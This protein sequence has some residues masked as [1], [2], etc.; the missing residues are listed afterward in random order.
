MALCFLY[1]VKW[2]V[3]GNAALNNENVD[4]DEN[5][6]WLHTNESYQPQLRNVDNENK[7]VQLP[8]IVIKLIVSMKPPCHSK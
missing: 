3:D 5:N 7:P 4:L 1:I 8:S 2:S 6:N